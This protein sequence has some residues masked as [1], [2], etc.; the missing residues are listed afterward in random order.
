M[1]EPLKRSR[2][3]SAGSF[4][5]ALPL[6]IVLLSLVG[7]VVTSETIRRDRN[8]DAARRVEVDTVGA[9]IILGRARAY[10]VG[11]GN[12]LAGEP[13]PG[14]QRFV[15]MAGGT[16]GGGGLLDAMW[17]ERVSGSAR[18]KYE[19][20]IGAP[21]TR[22]TP[23]GSFE[24]APPAASYL[25]AT[26]TT[27][28]SP[29]LPPGVDVSRG[30]ALPP[31]IRDRSSA[32][33]VSASELGSLGG[34]PG[35]YLLEAGSFG[36]GPNS[37]G[38]LVVFVPQGWLTASIGGDPRRL[39]VGLDGRQLEGFD[40]PPACSVSFGTLGRRWRIDVAT[41]PLTGFQTLLPSPSSPTPIAAALL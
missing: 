1:Y 27:N 39:A 30:P 8:S 38:Y 23:A 31:A 18:G 2:L 32:S 24:P 37:R 5:L 3:R 6:L 26:F 22:R 16:A 19:A 10:V 28:G 17:G 35:F 40:S 14:P 12:I 7:Y 34:R 20:R 21:I 13:G 41:A 9:Q 36:H 25:A 33:A 15:Q 29:E 4:G 11:L